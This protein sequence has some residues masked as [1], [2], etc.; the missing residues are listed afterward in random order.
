MPDLPSD[1][2]VPE[3]EEPFATEEEFDNM[4]GDLRR[5]FIGWLKKTESE[6]QM[7]KANLITK[8]KEFAAE[9]N[10]FYTTLRREIKETEQ[11]IK[12]KWKEAQAE[13]EKALKEV[14]REREE[15]RAKLREE[16]KNTEIENSRIRQQ[17]LQDREKFISEYENYE[18]KKRMIVDSNIATAT[19]V[20]LNVGGAVFSSAR[21]TLCQ[22]KDSYLE[23]LLSGNLSVQRD[24]NG[25]IF[26]DRDSEL[27]RLILNFLR[28]P[29][30]PPFPR[31]APESIAL[32]KEAEFYGVHFF[33]YSLAF[34]CGGHSGVEHLKAVELLDVA[35]H[36]WRACRPMDTERAYFGGSVLPGRL[37]VFGG[38]NIEYRALCDVEIYDLLRDTWSSGAPLNTP[39]R[40]NCSATSNERIFTL[41][42]FD[43]SNILRS[44]EAYDERMKNWLELPPFKTP[45]SSATCV[46]QGERLFLSGGS[47][48]QRLRSCEIYDIRANKWEQG[49]DMM[50]VRSAATGVGL[51]NHVFCMGGVDTG[52]TIS[53][54]MEV[55]EP[56]SQRWTYRQPMNEHRMDASSA[57]MN[58]TI[59]VSGGQNTEVLYSSEFYK[60]DSDQWHAGPDMLF[61]RYGHVLLLSNL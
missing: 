48:G 38:Q 11:K 60:P 13:R 27:F 12:N 20:E 61:P 23:M 39:R 53:S 41:G 50:E 57:V 28:D 9:K 3:Q 18:A 26:I 29:T 58:E 4:V 36:T 43:G 35:N 59:L 40:N 22:E 16:Q 37:F 15:A 7:E 34:A 52:H 44:M 19:S 21:Q 47:S 17:I 25:R 8:R 24:A 33:P 2:I 45:R 32:A 1:L 6:L 49:P 42:G 31:D 51:F 14:A 10:N 54:S 30:T 56:R 55:L 46:V 5:S